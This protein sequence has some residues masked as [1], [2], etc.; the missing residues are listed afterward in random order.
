[1]TI[2]YAAN[3][4]QTIFA[5]AAY[6]SGN[7]VNSV[8]FTGVQ[9]TTTAGVTTDVYTNTGS[10]QTFRFDTAGSVPVTVSGGSSVGYVFAS[11]SLPGSAT[12]NPCVVTGSYSAPTLST[13]TVI[14]PNGCTSTG[15][16]AAPNA[17]ATVA[18]VAAT[19]SMVATFRAN[20]APQ[21]GVFAT[22]STCD[23]TSLCNFASGFASPWTGSFGGFSA[24]GY[25][26]S[27]TLAAGSTLVPQTGTAVGSALILDS[28]NS[29][30]SF[31]NEATFGGKQVPITFP[32]GSTDVTPPTCSSAAFVPATGTT[33]SSTF[34][35]VLTITCQDAGSGLY[36]KGAFGTVS[37]GNTPLTIVYNMAGATASTTEI[38][39][40]YVS[41][42]LQ[43]VGVW[44][45]D[46]ALNSVLYG[47]C[48]TS[49][50]GYTTIGCSAG[51]GS[52]SSSASSV[53][54]SIF[55]L[56]ALVVMA[57]FA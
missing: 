55:A 38:F 24:L 37:V 16:T 29:W 50:A 53:S 31:I 33:V 17:T 48:G 45:V 34:S 8:Q 36:R 2:T 44:A 41:G 47:G 7:N 12:G 10:T 3:T 23:A 57:L 5:G 14:S 49:G 1:M 6:T 39:P 56:F 54:L 13:F 43:I 25:A 11:L 26:A 30:A 20:T 32:V 19:W 27:N 46:N 28:R 18:P 42:Q 52:G 9:S 4:N 40:P 35:T 22:F 21:A 51:G 15:C